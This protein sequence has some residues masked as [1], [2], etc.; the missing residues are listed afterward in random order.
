MCIWRV[1]IKTCFI[2]KQSSYKRTFYKKIACL[3]PPSLPSSLPLSPHFLPD[4]TTLQSRLASKSLFSSDWPWNSWWSSCLIL[5]LCQKGEKNQFWSTSDTLGTRPPP[6]SLPP[7]WDQRQR[8][9]TRLISLYIFRIWN[10]CVHFLA[11]QF[12][13]VFVFINSK[14]IFFKK[15]NKTTKRPKMAVKVAFLVSKGQVGST[16]SSW[17]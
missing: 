7:P 16:Q 5:W 15:Q 2:K 1:A 12:F 10:L 8:K 13:L 11:F 9:W 4:S 6:T 17:G 14:M 3:Q